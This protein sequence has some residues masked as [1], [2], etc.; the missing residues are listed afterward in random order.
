MLRLGWLLIG[1]LEIFTQ[2]KPSSTL[3]VKLGGFCNSTRDGKF[4]KRLLKHN[5][6]DKICLFFLFY[7]AHMK[8]ALKHTSQ[9]FCFSSF[10]AHFSL[11]GFFFF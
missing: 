3:T 11:V 5:D 1:H 6:V 8:Y 9:C 2:P 4:D 7:V 10:I